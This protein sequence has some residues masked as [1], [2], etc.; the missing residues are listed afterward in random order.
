LSSKIADVVRRT[1][2]ALSQDER[3]S[4][5][6]F[7]KGLAARFAEIDAC[8]LP[9]TLIHGDCHP[10]NFRGTAQGLTLLDWGDSGMGHP[11][12]DQP[13]FLDGVPPEHVK[14][15][16]DHW[17]REWLVRVPGCD[18]VRAADLLAP[19]ATARR[20]VIYQRFIDHIEP[21]ERIYHQ[22]DP[23]DWLRQTAALVT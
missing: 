12:L 3:V 18:P 1:S 16:K 2:E 15:I 19:I 11:L 9:D 21:S 14:T 23:L 5:R 8:G 20:A 6:R 4:L 13:A 7:V 17:S 10:G 22:G